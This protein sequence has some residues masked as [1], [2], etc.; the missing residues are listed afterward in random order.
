MPFLVAFIIWYNIYAKK[1]PR[2]SRTVEDKLGLIIV[3]FIAFSVITS[4]LP[5]IF[6]IALV[7]IVFG[8]FLFPF[9]AIVMA[10]LHALGIIRKP[11]N[12]MKDK[13][14][15]QVYYNQFK[16]NSYAKDRKKWYQTGTKLTRT[17]K[18]RRKIIEKFNDKY[19]LTL[20]EEEIDRIVD[21]S[22]MSYCWEKEIYDMSKH[23]DNISEWYKSDTCWLR[24]YIKVFP[25]QSISSDF[26]R[27]RRIC[28]ETF[29]LIFDQMNPA[30]YSTIEACVE[31]INT[32]YFSFFDDVTF[33]IA[34]RFLDAVGYTYELPKSEVIQYESE[35]ERLKRKYDE[36]EEQHKFEQRINGGQ[37][38]KI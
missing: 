31:D 12:P 2:C 23:Y 32:R 33:M 30:S 4:A 16:S 36:E 18:K 34:H 37:R 8:I 21:A 22:Y 25:V 1:N 35:L 26:E 9:I 20:T 5:F 27:Q 38:R 14:D 13:R 19:D 15:E 29:K 11:Y 7:L 10:V 28:I 6:D 17:V 24:A 3:G